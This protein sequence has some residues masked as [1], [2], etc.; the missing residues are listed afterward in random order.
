[1][2]GD[3]LTTSLLFEL[4]RAE[5][6]KAQLHY[7]IND[8]TTAAIKGNPFIDKLWV[9][10]SD[11]AQKKQ[12]AKALYTELKD[13]SFDLI[14]DVYSKLGS[15]ALTR[16]LNASQSIGYY[17]WYLTHN[18]KQTV[19][20]LVNTDKDEGLA[21]VN[22]VLLLETLGYAVQNIPKP[23]I[24]LDPAEINTA[25]QTLEQ[26]KIDGSQPLFMISLLG[27]SDLKT[28]PIAYMAKVLDHLVAQTNGKLLLNYIPI[29]RAKVDAL[30]DYCQTA[31]REHIFDNIYGKSLREFMA[32]TAQCDALIGNEGGAVN[33]A[34]ALE[35]PTY[36]IFAPWILKLAWNSFEQ[37]NINRSIHLQD[38]HPELFAKHPKKYKNQAL[39]LY[40]QLTPEYVIADL[41]QFL[42]QHQF[43]ASKP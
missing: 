26:A 15:A 16:K 42:T 34:K 30:L 32:L 29:Q 22:R 28:Y 24:Y 1:M 12:S 39:E 41:N 43:L 20:P 17:K 14:I 21:I 5:H 7:L 40:K 25:K 8:N 19:K 2:I 23:K 35:V 6:P 38:I 13:I 27:S 11:V 37:A 9:Q 4:L 10:K 3:V 31:T 18:Y 33:M 36:S